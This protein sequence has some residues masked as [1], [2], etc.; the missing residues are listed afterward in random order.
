MR[1]MRPPPSS[2][3]VLL[4]VSPPDA[5]GQ[6]TG[7]FSRCGAPLPGARHDQGEVTVVDDY[8]IIPPE[9]RPAGCGPTP[10]PLFRPSR[11][12]FQPHLFSRTVLP[13]TSSPNP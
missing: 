12:I 2:A 3:A 4:G 5:D 9:S 11:V 7:T 1:A 13:R 8:A 6:A 10:V